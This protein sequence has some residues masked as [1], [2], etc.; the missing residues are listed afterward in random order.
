MNNENDI[1][2]RAAVPE[3]AE[4]LADARV[5]QLLDE[6]STLKYDTRDEMIDFFRRKIAGGSYRA[7]IAEDRGVFVSTAAVLYQEYP[8]SIGW[9]GA[10]RGYIAS[11]YTVPERRGEGLASMLLRLIIEDAREKKL[12]NLWMMASKD[13]RRLYRKFGFDDERAGMDVYMEWWED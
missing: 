3:D 12:G 11:V 13:G 2:V 6:G 10:K 7:W 4:L 9:R 8:P 1:S 5:R